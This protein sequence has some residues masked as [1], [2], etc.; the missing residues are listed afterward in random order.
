ML[1]SQGKIYA[2]STDGFVF[3]E[4][5]VEAAKSARNR[6]KL[7]LEAYRHRLESAAA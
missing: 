4:P 7:A 5:Q 3:S 1:E 2:S 6:E